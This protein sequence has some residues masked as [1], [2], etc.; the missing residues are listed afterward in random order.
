MMIMNFTVRSEAI[1]SET[2]MCEPLAREALTS[3]G[4][5]S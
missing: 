1:G 5:R 2:L 4:V 3:E